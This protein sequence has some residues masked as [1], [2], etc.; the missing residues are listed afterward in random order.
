M[1]FWLD[2]GMEWAQEA[3]GMAM[4]GE[5]LRDIERR[6]DQAHRIFDA[7]AGEQQYGLLGAVCNEDTRRLHDAKCYAETGRP[8]RAAEIYDWRRAGNRT[9]RQRWGSGRSVPPRPCTRGAP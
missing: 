9:R 2:R 1:A 7:A 5:P 6:L 8:V 4:C 3:L